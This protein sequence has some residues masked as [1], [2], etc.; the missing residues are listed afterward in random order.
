MQSFANEPNKYN[1][2]ILKVSIKYSLY[3]LIFL[4]TSALEYLHGYFYSQIYSISNIN[5]TSK[6]K[7]L[8][9]MASV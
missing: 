6:E 5:L 9:T 8:F 2:F 1:F 4:I 7:S 3:N